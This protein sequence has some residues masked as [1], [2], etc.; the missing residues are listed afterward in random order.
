MNVRE[1]ILSIRLIEKI[2]AVPTYPQQLGIEAAI[3]CPEG[4]AVT[5]RKE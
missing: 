1:R 2:H 5:E 3:L 4:S